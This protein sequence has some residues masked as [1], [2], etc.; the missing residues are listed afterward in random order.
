MNSDKMCLGRGTPI[1]EDAGRH[2]INWGAAHAGE[3]PVGVRRRRM[4]CPA[5]GR[6]LM[7]SV[8]PCDDGCHVI[9]SLPPHKRKGWWQRKTARSAQNDHERGRRLRV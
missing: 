3:R 7:S 6:R 5:C 1:I 4:K 2:R 8:R 9:H